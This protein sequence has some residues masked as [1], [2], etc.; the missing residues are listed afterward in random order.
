[1]SLRFRLRLILVGRLFWQI[2]V[3]SSSDFF[4]VVTVPLVTKAFAF[5]QKFLTTMCFVFLVSMYSVML[6]EVSDGVTYIF[7]S[8]TRKLFSRMQ[9]H[10]LIKSALRAES[11]FATFLQTSEDFCSCTTMFSFVFR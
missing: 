7:T 8:V 1:M 2:N 5:C 6:L 3:A 11:S 10:M 9:L 4:T